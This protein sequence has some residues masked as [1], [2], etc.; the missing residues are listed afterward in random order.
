MSQMNLSMKHSLWQRG[1]AGGC[2]GGGRWGRRE[3]EVGVSR[4]KLLY[5]KWIRNKVLLYSMG[6]YIHYPMI[7]R[8]ENNTKN[9]GYMYNCIILLYDRS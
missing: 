1:Q 9:N 6:N 2:Q 7:S 4:Y 5:I 3:W 8:M